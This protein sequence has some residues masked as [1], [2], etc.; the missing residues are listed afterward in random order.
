[1]DG[2]I[3]FVRITE[4]MMKN[5]DRRERGEEQRQERG[6]ERDRERNI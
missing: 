4:E 5:R 3:L 1:M 6:K 2:S